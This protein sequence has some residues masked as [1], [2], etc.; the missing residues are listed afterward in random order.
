MC[1]GRL[2]HVPSPLGAP[3]IPADASERACLWCRGAIADDKRADAKFCD[4]P[5][6]QAFHRFKPRALAGPARGATLRAAYADPP[7]LGKSHY[8]RGHPDY[9]GEVDHAELIRRLS[10]YDAWAL[11]CS[12][13]SLGNLLP[14]CG[15]GARV[16]VWVKGPRATRSLRPLN[17]FEPVIYCGGRAVDGRR[18]TDVL[19]HGV[20]ARSSDPGW[21]IGAKPA[22]FCYWMF[23][24]LGLSRS[25]ELVDLFPGSGGVGRA[26]ILWTDRVHLEDAS[27]SSALPVDQG[28]DT[29]DASRRARISIRI[30]GNH[31]IAVRRPKRPLVSP[32]EGFERVPAYPNTPHMRGRVTA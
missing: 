15:P 20:A 3:V 7:Y 10:T 5:C 31:P 6:R 21:V 12:A 14:L 24:L 18:R 32:S 8:Y 4:T 16:A 17:A 23:D 22:A 26:W 19:T 11:S 25:D 13:E 27:T 2:A 9:A 30:L 28:L 1:P 29:R